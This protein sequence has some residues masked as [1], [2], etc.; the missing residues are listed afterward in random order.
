MVFVVKIELYC[1]LW[2][3]I[4]YLD[5]MIIMKIKE[6]GGLDVIVLFYFYYYLM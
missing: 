6:F 5:E 1:L 4:M 2:D 3:C